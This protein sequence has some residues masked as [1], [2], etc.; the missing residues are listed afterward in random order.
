MQGSIKVDSVYGEGTTFTIRIP[1][2]VVDA[3]PLYDHEAKAGDSKAGNEKYTHIDA[4][5]LE[6]LVVDDNK[7]NLTV[8]KGL[9]KPT[10][11]KVDT[12]L[13]GAECLEKIVQK[14]YDFVLLDHMMPK[15]VLRLYIGQ[16]PLKIVN[17]R[18]QYLL[19]LQL[20]QYRALKNFI[21]RRALTIM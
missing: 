10:K 8:A 15:M 20:M 16:K 17:A 2:K 4:S 13:S 1:Q 5:D 14:H 11:A 3:A 19:P 12:C 7:L 9:L 18:I 6:I 21:W